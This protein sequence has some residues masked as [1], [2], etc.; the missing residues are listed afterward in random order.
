M[1]M[2]LKDFTGYKIFSTS[3][4]VEPY[5]GKIIERTIKKAFPNDNNSTLYVVKV[6]GISQKL[7]LYEDEML[8]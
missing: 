1:K 6:K 5:N 7:E 3:S 8:C 4:C 2:E